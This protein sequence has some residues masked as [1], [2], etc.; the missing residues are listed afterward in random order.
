MLAAL[1]RIESN[2]TDRA[3]TTTSAGHP[4]AVLFLSCAGVA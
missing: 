4:G 3:A 2:A 1:E